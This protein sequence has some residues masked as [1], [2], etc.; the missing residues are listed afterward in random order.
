LQLLIAVWL[1]AREARWHIKAVTEVRLQVNP[2]RFRIPDLMVLSVEAPDEK[3]V[4]TPPLLCIEILSP[5]DR[6]S[7]I[8]ERVRDYFR[9]GVPKCWIIDPALR[10]ALIATPGHFDEAVDG[11]L[12]AGEIEMPL[13]QVL[14]PQALE[15]LTA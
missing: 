11:I 2:T 10:S 15:P 7:R 6:M 12:R 4:R 3:I 8:M 13:A 9:M 14:E 1:F 5:E